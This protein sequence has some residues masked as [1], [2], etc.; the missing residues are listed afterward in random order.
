LLSIK[1]FT[2]HRK[3]IRYVASSVVV[4]LLIWWMLRNIELQKIYEILRKADFSKL[5]WIVIGYFLL[6]LLRTFRLHR[7]SEL[8]NTNP[9]ILFCIVAIHSFWNNILPARSGELSFFML[10]K[11]HLNMEI[12]RSAGIL[13]I[14]RFYDFLMTSVLFFSAIFLLGYAAKNS[15]LIIAMMTLIFIVMILS[16]CYLPRL[17]R[18]LI[19]FIMKIR[20]PSLL[21][22]RMLRHLNEFLY[23]TTQMGN[24]RTHLHLIVSTLF[25]NIS[26]I[27]IFQMIMISLNINILIPAVIV[28]SSFALFSVMLPINAPG[29]IGPLDAGW[30]LGFLSV[31]L[32]KDSAVLSAIVMHSMLLASACLVGI[33]GYIILLA[34]I[35]NKMVTGEL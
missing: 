1:I 31:G 29:N 22:E 14:I 27:F 17:I 33:F 32:D 35:R 11:R 25:C 12:G 26:T 24:M 7:I 5:I 15:L 21:R 23:S 13:V 6:C 3:Q 4:C 34:R 8:S 2:E 10:A 18:S 28:G 30:V 16:L 9:L 19:R 20:F